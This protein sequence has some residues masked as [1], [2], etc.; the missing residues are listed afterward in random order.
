MADSTTLRNTRQPGARLK[1]A[2]WVCLMFTVMVPAGRA[3]SAAGPQ[4]EAKNKT[5]KELFIEGEN[6]LRAGDLQRAAAAFRQVVAIDPQSAGAY[7]NLGVINMRRKQW[8]EALRMFRKADRLAP[9]VA[10][11]RLNIGLA[12]YR[13]NDFRN[14]IP[15][16]ESVVRDQPDSTQ[17]RYLLGLCYF[18][19][20]RW[21]EAVDTLQP[22]WG[23]QSLNM[24]YLY[25]LSI[26]A[27]KAGRKEVDDRAVA[28]LAQIGQ[29]TPEFH[30]IMGRAYLNHEEDDK[31]LEE[32]QKAEKS[33][34]KLPYVHY[35]MGMAYLHKKEWERAVEQ[36]RQEIALSPDA[37]FSYDKLASAYVSLEKDSLAEQNYRKA[38]QL[39][40]RLTSS[41]LGLAK[42]YQKQEKFAPALRAL[43]TVQKL[44]PEDYTAHYLRGQILQRM[45]QREKAKV[46]FDAYTRIMNA[47]REK[48]GKEL[49]GEIPSADITAEPQ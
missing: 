24:S 47:A 11:I 12:Y 34:P 15:P 25:V 19:T 7:A 21:A 45:G 20:D 48:R 41:Y 6:A 29:A 46:E 31:A 36:F 30:L 33:N 9:Q 13:Q 28:R 35:H 43:D 26:A 1:E 32:L 27:N 37:A 49:S 17:A 38:M 14:A 8:K 2:V 42:I 40:P 4:S 44:S 23:Q 16:F 5:P 10:G 18:F 22:L 39:D 3:Q